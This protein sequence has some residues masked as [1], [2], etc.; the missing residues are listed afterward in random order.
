MATPFCLPK[1]SVDGREP[2]G[3][4]NE[5]GLNFHSYRTDK[6]SLTQHSQTAQ[7]WEKALHVCGGGGSRK[8]TQH[9]A[10]CFSHCLISHYCQ[11]TYSSRGTVWK[12][13]FTGKMRASQRQSS[14]EEGVGGRRGEW[15]VQESFMPK[16]GSRAIPK[17]L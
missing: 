13:N 9:R 16:A 11:S 6:Q 2:Q 4:S 15:H 7:H 10:P 5:I 14:Q 12:Q 8:R 1:P 3:I 17:A